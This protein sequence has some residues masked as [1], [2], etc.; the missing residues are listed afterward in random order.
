MMVKRWQDTGAKTAGAAG[1]SER[2]LKT[3]ETSEPAE[4]PAAARIGRPAPEFLELR[5]GMG[6]RGRGAAGRGA[7]RNRGVG[8]DRRRRSQQR[9]WG[10]IRKRLAP[11]RD[12]LPTRDRS[13]LALFYDCQGLHGFHQFAVGKGLAQRA[14]RWEA[15]DERRIGHGCQIEE[16]KP[17]GDGQEYLGSIGDDQIRL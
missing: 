4:K 10:G 11:R 8:T 16:V 3:D 7:G 14:G 9:P 17:V 6:G 1:W 2:S 5:G 12:R 15:G 13:P